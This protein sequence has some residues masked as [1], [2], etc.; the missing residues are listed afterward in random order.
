MMSSKSGHFHTFHVRQ[1]SE[2]TIFSRKKN[3]IIFV[4][5]TK[6]YPP[7]FHLKINDPSTFAFLSVCQTGKLDVNDDN[8]VVLARFFLVRFSFIQF[9]IFVPF[10]S[11]L[12]C[13]CFSPSLN[14]CSRYTF[15]NLITR[16][17]NAYVI[18]Y[19]G[20]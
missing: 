4:I 10:L 1:F 12:F 20:S 9:E 14:H 8:Y 7:N 5:F 16:N 3:D 6:T 2:R 15:F 17:Q 13:F 18:A 19:D 11:H